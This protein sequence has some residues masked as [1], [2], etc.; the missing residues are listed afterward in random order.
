MDRLAGMA[1]SELSDVGRVARELGLGDEG[2]DVDSRVVPRGYRV[3][4]RLLAS[5]SVLERVL[6][7]FGSVEEALRSS[8][9]E[10]ASAAGLPL[11]DV[12]RG[13]RGRAPGS[14]GEGGSVPARHG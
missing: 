10:L 3:L 8:D 6:E 4:A 9:E 14:L 11:G 2:F 1:T 7:H 12:A 13:R 5:P